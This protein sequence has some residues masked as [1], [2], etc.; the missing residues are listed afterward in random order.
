MCDLIANDNEKTIYFTKEKLLVQLS[1]K[2]NILDI[3]VYPIKNYYKIQNYRKYVNE[4]KNLFYKYHNSF[5]N[6]STKRFYVGWFLFL[7]EA[8]HLQIKKPIYG[9]KPFFVNN[10]IILSIICDDI[11]ED[12]YLRK[13][14]VE[15]F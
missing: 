15:D 8:G 9:Y 14:S 3:S 7:A 1:F 6:L 13:V 2:N 4:Y 12:F 10:I 11:N 5:T